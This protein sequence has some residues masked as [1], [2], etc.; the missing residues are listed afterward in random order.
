MKITVH[1]A[2]QRTRNEIA[3]DE[4]KGIIKE[5]A[6]KNGFKPSIS[7]RSELQL[8]DKSS[9]IRIPLADLGFKE[10]SGGKLVADKSSASVLTKLSKILK[11][12]KSDDALKMASD[13]ESKASGLRG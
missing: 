7:S 12:T 10:A 1:E 4:V 3:F 2:K 9:T 11:G 8:T 13:C 5:L 6:S